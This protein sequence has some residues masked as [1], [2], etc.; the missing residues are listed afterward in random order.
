MAFSHS[1]YAKIF[2][3]TLNT[4]SQGNLNNIDSNVPGV[5]DSV[6]LAIKLANHHL[7][8]NKSNK[9]SF[10]DNFSSGTKDNKVS[11]YHATLNSA[12]YILSNN[13]NTLKKLKK[14]F[15]KFPGNLKF[16]KDN[17][18]AFYNYLDDDVNLTCL[19]TTNIAELRIINKDS[20]INNNNNNNNNS[21]V[22]HRP[23]LRK[24][25]VFNSSD[26]NGNISFQDAMKKAI[27]V[28]TNINQSTRTFDNYLDQFRLSNNQPSQNNS[29][30]FNNNNNNNNNSLFHELSSRHDDL[31]LTSNNNNNNTSTDVS[32]SSSSSSSS[33]KRSIVSSSSSSKKLKTIDNC[34]I[35]LDV[36][37]DPFQL[38]CCNKPICWDCLMGLLAFD[39]KK[40]KD[41]ICPLCREPLD[42]N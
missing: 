6:G 16:V 39:G 15:T 42:L 27:E 38:D 22:I 17:F 24:T 1:T 35:C 26:V 25:V 2:F 36:P 5:N 32:S 14:A 19:A 33:N 28:S 8:T 10:L 18:A 11:L 31:L 41:S 40:D 12:Y 3:N 20:P 4:I 9:L 23:N 21:L 34:P 29:I 7:R 30:T 37:T 13:P